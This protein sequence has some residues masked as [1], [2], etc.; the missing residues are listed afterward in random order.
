MSSELNHQKKIVDDVHD[1][2]PK[3]F[4]MKLSHH[5]MSGIPDLI[6]K[7]PGYPV[8]FVEVKKSTINTKGVVK[9][10]TTDLQRAIMDHMMLSGMHC[11]VWTVIEDDDG[12]PMMLRTP[13]EVTSVVITDKNQLVKRKRGS[14]W[15]IENFLSTPVRS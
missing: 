9:I 13:P 4:A 12:L 14:K 5:F 2:C 6:I 11:E 3:S 8:T 1:Q 15:P 7:V 10:G